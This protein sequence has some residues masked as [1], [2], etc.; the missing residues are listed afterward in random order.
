[1]KNK[2]RLLFMGSKRIYKY[3]HGFTDYNSVDKKTH[4]LT[5]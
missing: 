1:M 4:S 5:K 2:P 3:S